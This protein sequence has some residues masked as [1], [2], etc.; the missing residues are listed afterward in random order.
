MARLIFPSQRQLAHAFDEF[1]A[2][3]EFF[4]PAFELAGVQLEQIQRGFEFGGFD[5]FGVQFAVSGLIAQIDARGDW[6][7][8]QRRRRVVMMAN[9]DG[10]LRGQLPFFQQGGADFG[11]RLVA[12]S[13]G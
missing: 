7:K 13:R 10:E 4:L 2:G 8:T 12:T 3:A 6:R 5:N 1:A 9:A 11:G